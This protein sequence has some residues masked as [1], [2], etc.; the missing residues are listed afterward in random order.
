MPT[1]KKTEKVPLLNTT[2]L[3]VKFN[4]EVTGKIIGSAMANFAGDEKP[5][6][7][8]DVNGER[9][10]FVLNAT[11]QTVLG[12]ALESHG[13]ERDTDVIP[14]NTEIKLEVYDTGSSGQFQYGVRI[15]SVIFPK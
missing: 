6:L 3:S 7:L 15:V 12:D 9:Y 5:K 13:L 14:E 8:L 1:L 11:S 4:K 10:D 2:I